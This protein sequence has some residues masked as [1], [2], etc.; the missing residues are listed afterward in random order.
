[1]NDKVYNIIIL[2]AG[3]AGIS[4]ANEAEIFGLKDILILEK[5]DTHSYTIRNFYEDGKPIDRDWAGFKVKLLGNIDFKFVKEDKIDLFDEILNKSKNIELKYNSEVYQI[6]KKDDIFI[7]ESKSGR[8]SSKNIVIAIGR[9]SKP[10]KPDYKLP[11]KLAKKINF[12]LSKVSSNEKIVVVGGGD[13]ASEYAVS[14]SK[15]NNVTITYRK[16]K[17]TRPNPINQK[18]L[19]DKFDDKTLSYKLGVDIK[20]IQDESGLIK[21]IYSDESSDTYD[22]MIFALGGTTPIDFIVNSGI[23]IDN[24]SQPIFDENNE[25]AKKG[26]F[27]AGDI[28]FQ[29]GGSISMAFNQGYKIAKYITN[30]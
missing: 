30:S 18:K 7:V 3:P 29:N 16:E 12:D 23:E 11:R 4:V 24:L 5:T 22:R 10:K 2:G 13:S 9:M 21:I 25:T 17:F 20:E 6:V 15:T 26:L 14:L 27:V 8:Y 1:M 28:V 19:Q